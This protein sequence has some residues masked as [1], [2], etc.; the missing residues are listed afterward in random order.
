MTLPSSTSC[1]AWSRP[2]PAPRSPSRATRP[3][4]PSPYAACAWASRSCSPTAA[5]RSVVD[6]ETSTGKGGFDVEVVSADRVLE[7]APALTVVQALPKGDRGE[8]AVEV[9][10]EVGVAP[11][12]AVGGPAL[13]GGVEGASGLPRSLARWRSTAR[14][15]A[16]GTRR[17]WHPR[18]RR[19]GRH[20]R[21]GRAAA[22]RRPGGGAARGRDRAAVGRRRAAPAAT[23]CSWWAPRAASRPTSW[24]PSPRPARA[25]Y[26]WARRCCAPRPPGWWPAP[27]C[28]R[29]PPAGPDDPVLARGRPVLGWVSSVTSWPARHPSPASWEV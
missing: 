29:A 14:E 1:R 11:G 20:R 28:W 4:T 22:R 8:L 13:G 7:P 24:P 27:R 3:T 23:S 17:S 9:L 2:R 12:R 18:G 25:S 21:G 10:T 5:D 16:K 19:A 15:A 26:A 6:E